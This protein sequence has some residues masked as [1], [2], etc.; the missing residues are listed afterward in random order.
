MKAPCCS[1]LKCRRRDRK[2][3][4]LPKSQR[5]WATF[6]DPNLAI[7]CVYCMRVFCKLCAFKHFKRTPLKHRS[8]YAN[9][10]Q[11]RKRALAR[12]EAK[13]R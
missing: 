4:W 11:R 7:R 1:N 12:K 6:I 3:T 8:Y 5:S 10:V 9:K 13:C 2:L